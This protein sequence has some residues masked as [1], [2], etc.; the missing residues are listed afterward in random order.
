M[1]RNLIIILLVCLLNT[2]FAQLKSPNLIAGYRLEGNVLDW[3]GN[4]YN[5]TP[6]GT[7]TPV[8]IP[9]GMF[10]QAIDFNTSGNSGFYITNNSVFSFTT[11]SADKP[12]TIDFWLYFNAIV[13]NNFIIEKRNILDSLEY[14]LVISSNI[15]YMILYNQ[16]SSSVYLGV[17][18]NN[19]FS[20]T[21][22]YHVAVTYSGSG[23]YT[24]IKL[25]LNGKILSTTNY[26]VGVYS[27]MGIG[28]VN[29]HIGQSLLPFRVNGK[30]DEI[31]FYNKALTEG[32]IRQDMLNF[33]PNGL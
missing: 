8:Y 23:A 1:M 21:T 31:H 26:S 15:L 22:W 9:G 5:G 20:L 32:E 14:E 13:T 2:G 4:G 30:M 19:P 27:A 24:G 18:I 12:F 7:P 28:T 29:V 3:S 16:L 33:T 17:G 25:Y 11:G 10:G 6:V